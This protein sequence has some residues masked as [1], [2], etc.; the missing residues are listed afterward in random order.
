MDK[1]SFP[2]GYHAFH[3]DKDINFQLNRIY[4]FGEWTKAD[5]EEAGKAIKKIENWAPTLTELAERQLENNRPL[6]AA[7]SYRAAEFY[8]LPGDPLKMELYDQFIQ[9]F[10]DSL[11]NADLERIFIPYRDGALP[12]LRLSQENNRGTIVV[13]GGFDSFMEEIVILGRY[14]AGAG[15]EVI[16][17]EG[18]GQGAAIRKYDLIFTHKWEEP[19]A[20][21][22]DHFDLN[23]VTLIGISLGGYLALRAAAFEKRIKRVVCY[24]ISNYDQHGKGLQR[25]IYEFFLRKPAVYNWIAEKS[26]KNIAVEW[27][28]RHGMY[29]NGVETP[30]EWM[31]SLE[32]F[33]VV[34]IA[35]KVHQ[36]VLLLA[37]AEDHMVNI[38]EFEKNRRGLANAR[39]V[40][41]RIFTA[42]EQ[43]QNHCQ[44]GNV[45]L[46]LDVILDWVEAI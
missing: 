7:F 38:K 19:V 20:A 23:D 26:M 3:K 28:I 5:A 16:I 12:A 14:L 2:V 30:V 43:A 18:P 37:G 31:A 41:G 9:L 1:P 46:A 15:Y 8:V 24:D 4:S 45:K 21:V 39:S 29:I 13:H 36:D 35:D 40:T 25:S 6:A 11:R 42:E 27:L 32:N 22:L 34:D 17:F 33:S 10:Y 44:I